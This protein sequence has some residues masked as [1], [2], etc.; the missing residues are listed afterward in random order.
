MKTQNP[1]DN[2]SQEGRAWDRGWCSGYDDNEETWVK[3]I[4]PIVGE[5]E[6]HIRYDWENNDCL[7]VKKIKMIFD[8]FFQY[9]PEHDW[10]EQLVKD[11]TEAYKEHQWDDLS[12]SEL[13]DLAA[14][15][16]P[17]GISLKKKW[18]VNVTWS[19]TIEVE[20]DDE[21]SACE[22]AEDKIREDSNFYDILANSE[23]EAE[24]L[25]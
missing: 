6:E 18:N 22:L 16:K 19:D 3:Q 4:L 14:M 13:E 10:L 20:A 8:V 12:S 5:L 23:F 11:A 25:S 1:Y 21:D 7:Q 24:E 2:V 15:G 9:A 17:F